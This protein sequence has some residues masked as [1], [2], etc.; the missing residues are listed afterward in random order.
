[1]GKAVK[2]LGGWAHC[3]S[4][5]TALV[6]LGGCGGGK[7]VVMAPLET[8]LR[9]A[10][11]DVMEENPTVNVPQEIRN[12]LRDKIGQLLYEE[13]AFQRGTDLKIK[14]H[15]IYF[16]PG[17]QAARWAAGP[18]GGEAAQGSL[19]VQAKYSD[20]TGREVATIQAEGFIGGGF[21]GGSFNNAID[22]AAKQIAEYTK[23]NFR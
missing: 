10:T 11:V 19:I 7:T 14:Y 20:S 1:M 2:R 9:V 15:F 4:L 21:L 22:N 5:I 16:N 18:F 6:L 3:Y 23:R 12:S 17:S 13:G 8:Q